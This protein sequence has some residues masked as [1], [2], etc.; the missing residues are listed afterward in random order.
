MGK[1]KYETDIPKEAGSAVSMITY[2]G[3]VLVACQYRIYVLTDDKYFRPLKFV[4]A[5]ENP[6]H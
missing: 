3:M 2:K 5:D 6:S 1:F 4:E